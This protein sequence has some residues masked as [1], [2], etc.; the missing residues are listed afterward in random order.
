MTHENEKNYTIELL[1]CAITDNVPSLPPEGIDWEIIFNFAQRHNLIS[2]IYFG[3]QKLPESVQST[4]TYFNRYLFCYK[5]ILVKDANRAYE[6]ELLKKDFEENNIDYIL[7]KG[8]VTKYLY[9][10]TSMRVMSDVDIFYRNGDSNI[11]DKIFE[12]RGYKLHNKEPKEV[13]YLKADLKLKFEMQTQ[14]VD[15]GYK[16]WFDY[17]SDIWN[18]LIPSEHSHEYHMTDEDFYL[19]HIIHMAKHFKNGG[20]GL[21]HLLDV[22]IIN[23]S[24]TEMNWDYL[25]KELEHLKLNTFEYNVRHLVGCWFGDETVAN[26]DFKRTLDLLGHYIFYSGAFGLTSQKE[27]NAIVYRNDM[28]VSWRKKIFPDLNTM[29]DYY[30]SILKK[31]KWLVPFYWIRLNFKRIFIDRKNL[32]SN[33]NRLNNI[34][35]AN[36]S[37]TKELMDRCGMTDIE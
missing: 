24:Y 5:E 3:M 2:T 28:A 18:R 9:P 32:K 1:K 20:I 17:L 10:D 27:I 4:I 30:G 14:L 8:S 15:E 29:V 12:A 37:F 22:F 19:Y 33:I 16:L 31:H 25:N 6:I 13:S 21:N 34:S 11:I 26:D 23:K 7:L 35:D 36:I